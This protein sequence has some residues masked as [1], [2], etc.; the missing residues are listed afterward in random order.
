[1]RN[2][3]VAKFST[4]F[5]LFHPWQRSLFMKTNFSSIAKAI[6]VTGSQ[7][8]F[9]FSISGLVSSFIAGGLASYYY[10]E[11]EEITKFAK[12]AAL[13]VGE[14]WFGEGFKETFYKLEETEQMTLA[15]KLLE[16]ESSYKSI[17]AD[18]RLAHTSKA[19][20]TDM[21]KKLISEID[22]LLKRHKKDTKPSKLV[23]LKAILQDK[24][25]ALN[26]SEGQGCFEWE[27]MIKDAK[28]TIES[29]L[30]LSTDGIQISSKEL[31]DKLE[32]LDVELIPAYTKVIYTLGRIYI[33]SRDEKTLDRTTRCF[34]LSYELSKLYGEK[35]GEKLFTEILSSYRGEGYLLLEGESREELQEAVKLYEKGIT[36]EGSYYDTHL[37]DK[38]NV[39]IDTYF[40][41]ECMNQLARCYEKLAR[42]EPDK[43][44]KRLYKESAMKY[45]IGDKLYRNEGSK[46]VEGAINLL[47][48]ERKR[49]R[50][51]LNELAKI[52][53]LTPYDNDQDEL[54]NVLV[55]SVRYN[56]NLEIAERLYLD[57]LQISKEVKNEE[58]Y[59]VSDAKAGLARVY[60]LLGKDKHEKAL[61]FINE[62]ID[63]QKKLGRSRTHPYLKEAIELQKTIQKF[64]RE[65]D[66]GRPKEL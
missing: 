2:Y 4:P 28:Q 53:M 12:A 46:V 10:H 13:Q 20:I 24:L 32:K 49:K 48:S 56:N 33:Y 1:M 18:N 31:F 38:I 25:V 52:L 6:P 55:G 58:N 8:Q 37:G 17:N 5:P 64:T 26:L 23:T 36:L 3:K 14:N 7:R 21:G 9:I 65:D 42:I 54:A 61:E 59:Q 35:R 66:Y 39:G 19:T 63:L 45:L 62:S 40:K 47:S 57:S 44:Q 60:F 34:N 15:K 50:I 16:I 43:E 22:T 29:L 27:A 51:Y 41:A 30:D 11:N